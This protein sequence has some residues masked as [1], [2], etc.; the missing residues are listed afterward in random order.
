MRVKLSQPAGLQSVL[1]VA[2]KKRYCGD[3]MTVKPL[4][5]LLSSVNGL[6]CCVQRFGSM[7]LCVCACRGRM[8]SV[9]SRRSIQY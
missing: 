9:V 7:R 3:L 2:E 4:V 8:A 6:L 1:K 5:P